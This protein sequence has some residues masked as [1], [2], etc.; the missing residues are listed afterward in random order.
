MPEP[1]ASAPQ[2]KCDTPHRD[3]KHDDNIRTLI[4]PDIVRDV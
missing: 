4:D 2:M 3:F 1:I